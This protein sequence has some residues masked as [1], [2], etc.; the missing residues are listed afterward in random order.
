M[1]TVMNTL[2]RKA[3]ERSNIHPYYIDEISSRYALM[4]ENMVDEE[5]WPLVQTMV[6][7]YCAYV[8]RYSFCSNIHRW[9]KRSSIRST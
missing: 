5:S 8:R 4:I 6:K 1:L 3:I 9:C 2:L 7:E